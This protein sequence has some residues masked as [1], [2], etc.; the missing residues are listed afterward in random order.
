M[1]VAIPEARNK[2]T[3]ANVN[4]KNLLFNAATPPTKHSAHTKKSKTARYN[5][6]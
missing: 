6:G 4:G 2:K 1:K 5:A 3:L